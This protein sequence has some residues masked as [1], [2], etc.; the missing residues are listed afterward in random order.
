MTQRSECYEAK[1]QLTHGTLEEF[2]EEMTPK[3]RW[4]KWVSCNKMERKRERAPSRRRTCKDQELEES[5]FYFK[6]G[7]STV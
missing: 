5:K 1:L 7:I 6:A 4:E 3:W 2:L